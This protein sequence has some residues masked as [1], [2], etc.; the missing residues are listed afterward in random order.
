LPANANA[1]EVA[2]IDSIRSF[3]SEVYPDIVASNPAQDPEA[4]SERVRFF[5]T[6]EAFDT[7]TTQ[8]T[9]D[10]TL[11]PVYEKGTM[12]LDKIVG[13]VSV[14][15]RTGGDW[16]AEFTALH[17]SFL[18]DETAECLA[19]TVDL[20]SLPLAPGSFAAGI[21]SISAKPPRINCAE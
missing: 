2:D 15:D 20:V 16:K 3:V 17:K 19:V 5:A 14:Y 18:D 13:K 21:T 7:Y 4:I 10:G 8:K 11:S 1:I 6:Q 9:E 12:V